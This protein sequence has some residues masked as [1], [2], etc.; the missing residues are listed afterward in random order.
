MNNRLEPIKQIR[1][2]Q[3]TNFNIA[4]PTVEVTEEDVMFEIKR[5]RET[6]DSESA[7]KTEFNPDE[8]IARSN[9]QLMKFSET[10]SLDELRAKLSQTIYDHKHQEAHMIRINKVMRKV[11]DQVEIE[12]NEEVI[13]QAAD[14]MYTDLEEQLKAQNLPIS[15]Y[16][17]YNG[18]QTEDE[19]RHY[20]QSEVRTTNLEYAALD[21]IATKEEIKVSEDE[22]QAA[23]NEYLSRQEEETSGIEDKAGFRKSILYTKVVDFLVRVNTAAA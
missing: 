16:L 8:A 4:V 9:E 10:S 18:F 6:L 19:L 3:Y 14:I 5:L 17:K 23:K 1:L 21:E 13:D 11:L 20:L 12:Y 2:G 15:A 7:P 22:F